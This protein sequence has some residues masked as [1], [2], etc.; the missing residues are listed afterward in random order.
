MKTAR[1]FQDH[2]VIQRNK[3][4]FIW[5]TGEN[6]EHVRAEFGPE[7][8][9]TIVKDGK[10]KLEFSPVDTAEERIILVESEKNREVIRDV[11]AGE[12]W[13]AG[14][15]SNME[16]Y[17]LFDAD[18]KEEIKI[19]KDPDLRFFDYPEVSYPEQ[20]SDFDYSQ[21]GYWRKCTPDDLKYYSAAAYYFAKKLR[22]DLKV[23]VGIIGCNWGGTTASCWMSEKYVRQHGQVWFDDYEKQVSQIKD[24]EAYRTMYRKHPV[25]D[26][27]R[28]FDDPFI[29]KMM[30]VTTRSEQLEMMQNTSPEF[31]QLF[32][33]PFDPN[34][35]CG[36]YHTMLEHVGG[37]GIRGVIWYQGESDEAHADIYK[38]VFLD[39]VQCWRDLWNEC[40]P[41]ITVQLA[42]FEVWLGSDGKNFPEVRRQQRCAANEQGIYMVST[43]D[44]GMRYDIHPKKKKTVGFRLA[45]AA[46]ESLYGLHVCGQAPEGVSARVFEDEIEIRFIHAGDG[47]RIS[48]EQLQAMEIKKSDGS[49]VEIISGRAEREFLHIK[50]KEPVEEEY[51]ILFAQTPY[52]EVN[53]YNSWGIPAIPFSLKIR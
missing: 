44:V 46:E 22:G 7:I 27:G 13:L 48:G 49:A 45:M 24:I 47:L 17:M 16:F 36:L 6:G 33:S 5:G 53:L 29:L 25:N 8:R 26:K 51:R 50:L 43:S 34:R 28:P 41:F 18:Y 19:C 2:M 35:P 21:M 15:Q 3:P 42:P 52:Y 9:E 39:M 10:W 11:A 40:L 20:E 37:Y 23:P 30:G 14:G 32:N 12:V 31:Q 38:D 4:F 1:L